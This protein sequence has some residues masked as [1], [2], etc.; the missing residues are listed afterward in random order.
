[1]PSVLKEGFEYLKERN[2]PEAEASSE[3]LLSHTLQV[4][5]AQI[6]GGL[7]S[8][9]SPDERKRF[10]ELIRRRAAREPLAYVTGVQP[11]IDLEIRCGPGVLVPRPETEELLIE[12]FKK[13]RGREKE[14]LSFLDIG[15]GTGAI[16]I[17]LARHFK[18]S[19]VFAMEN[20]ARARNWMRKNLGLYPEEAKKIFLLQQDLSR[21]WELRGQELDLIISNPPYIPSS[22]IKKLEIEVLKEP[23]AALDGGRDGLKYLR[24]IISRAPRHLKPQ[25]LLS[26]E[27]GFNQGS[28]VK[29]IMESC[30]FKQ[31]EIK[32]DF[33]G[34]ERF[35]LARKD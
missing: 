24:R 27:I 11:F 26:V 28:G 10:L 8:S 3:F 33:A 29:K 9:I 32:K 6:Q 1:M 5:R 22:E 16:A 25:G 20:S 14:E 19:R 30:G 15:S 4:G 17:S 18:N 7:I 13:F 34:I 31:V 35:A 21:N 23:R 12:V 2:V